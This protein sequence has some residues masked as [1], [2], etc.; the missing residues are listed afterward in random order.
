MN[1]YSGLLAPLSVVDSNP[2]VS[3]A[4][5]NSF[6]PVLTAPG[7]EQGKSSSGDDSTGIEDD[8][9][10]LEAW[11]TKQGGSVKSWKVWFSL[12]LS[13]PHRLL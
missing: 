6:S 12:S 13:F 11:G 9:P 8:L 1:E 4:A 2:S 5:K 7:S 3:S 10:V